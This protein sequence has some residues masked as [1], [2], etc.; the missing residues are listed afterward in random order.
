MMDNRH[1]YRAWWFD[2]AIMLYSDKDVEGEEYV[3]CFEAGHVCC[4]VSVEKT[5]PDPYEPPY[6][7]GEKLD[8][9]MQCTGLVDCDEKEIYEGDIL[10]V[11]TL[12][13][14]GHK[15]T[16]VVVW[17]EGCYFTSNKDGIIELTYETHFGRVIGNIHDNPDLLEAK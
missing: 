4:Y 5:N 11:Q 6:T 8:N 17:L 15:R 10:E 2:G 16:G 14:R 12:S 1:K 13:D 7:E 3:F 9:V